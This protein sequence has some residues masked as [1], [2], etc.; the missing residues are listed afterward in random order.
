MNSQPGETEHKIFSLIHFM[1]GN[2]KGYFCHR[3][4][5][6]NELTQC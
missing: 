4:I 5:I 6:Q 1:H 2:I 3:K